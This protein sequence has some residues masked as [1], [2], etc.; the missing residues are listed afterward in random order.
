MNEK[1]TTYNELD[2]LLGLIQPTDAPQPKQPEPEPEQAA[3]D[4]K[5]ADKEEPAP[6]PEGG[7]DW[8]SEYIV[9]SPVP[10]CKTLY[11]TPDL[12]VMTPSC[13]AIS[14]KNSIFFCLYSSFLEFAFS[15]LAIIHFFSAKKLFFSIPYKYSCPIQPFYIPFERFLTTIFRNSY[16]NSKG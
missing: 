3:P 13:C 6:K 5:P 1:K 9:R 11:R 15:F 10:S 7:A 16:I 8:L 2:D 12:C 4:A 14:F